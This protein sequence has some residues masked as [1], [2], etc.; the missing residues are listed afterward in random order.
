MYII[1][2][3]WSLYSIL[4]GSS[5]CSYKLMRF[6]LQEIQVQVEEEARG[7][8][9]ARESYNI[10]ERRCAVLGGEVEELRSALES[11]SDVYVGLRG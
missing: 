6:L 5:N 3:F 7:R 10:A 2:S 1:A 4:P 9:E 11:V 8:E